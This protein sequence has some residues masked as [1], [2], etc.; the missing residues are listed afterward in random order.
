MT[1]MV[2]EIVAG[3]DGSAD[4][5]QALDWAVREA[6]TRGVPLTLSCV[7]TWIWMATPAARSISGRL[8]GRREGE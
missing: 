8:T 3:Y 1:G 7:G 4:S 2:H 5:E 6:R